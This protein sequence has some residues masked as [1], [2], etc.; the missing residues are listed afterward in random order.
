M[1]LCGSDWLNKCKWAGTDAAKVLAM[2]SKVTPLALWK[3]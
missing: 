1:A 3:V 2:L